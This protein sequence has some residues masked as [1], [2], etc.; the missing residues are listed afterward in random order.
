[1]FLT[2]VKNKSVS[3]ICRSS[4]SWSGVLHCRLPLSLLSYCKIKYDINIKTNKLSIF[5]NYLTLRCRTKIQYLSP[6]YINHKFLVYIFLGA[7]R[8]LDVNGSPAQL[9]QKSK[10]KTGSLDAGWEY[11]RPSTH[12]SYLDLGSPSTIVKNLKLTKF[13]IIGW[14]FSI[15]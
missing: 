10:V 11:C 1:M 12:N 4:E 7:D 2:N 8:V 9:K 13:E 15:T 14:N 3:K 6:F 5:W